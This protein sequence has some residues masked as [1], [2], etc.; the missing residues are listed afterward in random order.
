M[1]TIS[2]GY[3]KAHVKELIQ[4]NS[5]IPAEKLASIDKIG[6]GTVNKVI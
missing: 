2:L 3:L 1:L 4:P 6:F 5:I